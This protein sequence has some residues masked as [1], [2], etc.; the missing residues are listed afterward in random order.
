MVF[1]TTEPI[2]P[3]I[4]LLSGDDYTLDPCANIFEIKIRACLQFPDILPPEVLVL[5]ESGVL[6]DHHPAPHRVSLL[7]CE[8]DRSDLSLWKAAFCD[9]ANYGI[10]EQVATCLKEVHKHEPAFGTHKL[11][12]SVRL[13]D[14]NIQRALMWYGVDVYYFAREMEEVPAKHEETGKALMDKGAT[15]LLKRRVS[16]PRKKRTESANGL[17]PL[18]V[19]ARRGKKDTVQDLLSR[20]SDV[21]VVDNLGTSALF[22]AAVSDSLDTLKLIVKQKAALN[23]VSFYGD[24]VVACAANRDKMQ[25]VKYLLSVG[26]PLGRTALVCA[27]RSGCCN[28][29]NFVLEKDKSL[30]TEK[31]LGETAQSVSVRATPWHCNS[32]A[33]CHNALK[34]A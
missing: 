21:N 1:V 29:V 7:F 33:L 9:F 13:G 26:A 16:S 34:V 6:D 30:L 18:M 5:D 28:M 15:T 8:G 17:T 24:T 19:A 31:R 20:R 12:E 10:V 22:F 2:C 25:H 4:T 11:F 23:F 32:A 3:I 14:N 27:V